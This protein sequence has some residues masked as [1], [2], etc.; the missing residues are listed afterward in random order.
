MIDT[1]PKAR[2][3]GVP[4]EAIKAA[5]AHHDQAHIYWEWWTA[6]N[7]AG[8]HNPGA[9]RESLTRSVNE[10]QAGIKVLNDAIAAIKK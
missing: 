6:E 2:A 1:F 10:S 9:A 5:Q 3:A 8:F 7:S 4:E